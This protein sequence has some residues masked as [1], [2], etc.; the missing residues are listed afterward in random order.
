MPWHWSNFGNYWNNFNNFS[1]TYLTAVDD[2][3]HYLEG[4]VTQFDVLANDSSSSAMTLTEV[5]DTAIAIGDV[6]QLSGGGT[7]TYDGNG[8]FTFDTNG[9]Y[10]W[11]A[12]DEEATE[13]FFYTVEN[14]NGRVDT[15]WV[16]LHVYGTNDGPVA[17]ADTGAT[18]EDASV[19]LDV[20]A[21]DSDPDTND[22][23]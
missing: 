17:S 3:N 4:S 9:S 16:E 12:V 5:N 11:L 6:I 23:L 10:N 18:S 14:A 8:N 20:L 21:N 15:G 1:N 19:V 13:S 2:H 22:T 7:L